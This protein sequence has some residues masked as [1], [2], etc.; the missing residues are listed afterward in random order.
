MTPNK[1]IGYILTRLLMVGF[2]FFGGSFV[3][4][5]QE[6]HGEHAAQDSSLHEEAIHAA[7][8]EIHHDYETHKG[9]EPGKMIMEHIGDAYDLHFWGSHEHP[10]SMPLPVIIYQS[11][12]GFKTFLSSRFHHGHDTYQGYGILQEEYLSPVT[13]KTYF[14]GK[15][16]AMNEQ[17][18]VNEERN[19][20]LYNFSITKNALA[21]FIS[22]ILLILIMTSVAK[23]YKKREG[24]A[25]KGLQSFIEPIILFVRDDVAKPA[26]GK[27]YAKFMPYL[28]TIFFFIWINNIMGLIPL[29]PFGANV[30]GNVAVPIV[31][32]LFTFVIT[33]MNGN[34][35]YWRHIFAMPGVPLPVLLIVTPIEIMGM[36][37]K[38]IVLVIRLFANIT[39]GHIVLLVFFSLI[40]MFGETSTGVGLGVAVPSVIFTLLLNLLE[41]LVGAIQAYVF[42]LLSAIYF[43]MAVVD[44]GHH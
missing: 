31:L 28:L 6:G 12:E 26:I 32:A 7:G 13:G 21:I 1:Y 9:F 37:L 19:A 25:P 11:G 34:G 30:T 18:S 15:I 29:A 35:H 23:A 17:G 22:V 40:F 42:T 20:G 5:A 44:D 3:L 10:V 33:T 27:N 8:Q 16:V 4:A 43:G 24:Q 41:L 36:F 38:P 14:K 2:F 39:A